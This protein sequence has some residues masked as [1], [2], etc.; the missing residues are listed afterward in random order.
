MQRTVIIVIALVVAAVGA[1]V[2]PA[3][4]RRGPV[5]RVA[6]PV[7]Y[8]GLVVAPVPDVPLVTGRYQAEVGDRFAVGGNY[9]P[10]PAG[11]PRVEGDATVVRYTEMWT[12]PTGRRCG[13]AVSGYRYHLYVARHAGDV[14]IGGHPVHISDRP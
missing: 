9:D 3:L 11:P 7:Q 5:Y 13:R 8:I 14:V 10:L 12:A 1:V 4:A 2:G 6:C